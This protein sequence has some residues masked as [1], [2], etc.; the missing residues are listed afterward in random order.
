[1]IVGFYA[2]AHVKICNINHLAGF[3]GH[4][5]CKSIDVYSIL[6]TRLAGCKVPNILFPI[7]KSR[8]RILNV[9]YFLGIN[10]AIIAS[11]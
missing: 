9:G 3:D 7:D 11:A 1:M 2:P 5:F 4:S 8:A 6:S 10:Q